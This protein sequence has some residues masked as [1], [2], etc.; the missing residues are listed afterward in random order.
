MLPYFVYSPLSPNTQ[1]R[2]RFGRSFRPEQLTRSV[3]SV[4]QGGSDLNV[5]TI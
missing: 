1:R 5:E 3:V 4:R 2:F